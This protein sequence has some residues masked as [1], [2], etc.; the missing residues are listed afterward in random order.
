[1]QTTDV[2][3]RF[4]INTGHVRGHWVCVENTLQTVLAKQA[5]PLEVQ[6][7]LGELVS[8]VV[9]LAATLKFEG[10]IS[11]QARGTGPVSLLSV[12]CDHRQQVRALARW[13]E[14]WPEAGRASN[15]KTLLAD[16]VLAITISPER[17]ERYQGIVPLTGDRL[18]EC[19]E[20]YFEH[21]EQLATRLFL[22]HGNN[23]SSGLLIQRMP[24]NSSDP[25]P[26]ET[27]LEE[28]QRLAHLAETITAEELLNLECETVLHRLFHEETV[29]LQAPE[30]ISFHCSCSRERTAAA[31]RQLGSAELNAILA[32][33]GYV[34]TTCQFCSETYRFDPV[35]IGVLLQDPER[36]PPAMKGD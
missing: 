16:A 20:Y 17:G 24:T 23:R 8:A 4:I 28:W 27:L 29:S 25:T 11:I 7:L 10:T 36:V 19:I 22:A 2:S 1:M 34:D 30:P 18:S 35:D 5:Y 9:L 33:Q 14:D 12:E 13:Q 21:S 15:I 26:A 32:E 6:A 3:Q 31:L